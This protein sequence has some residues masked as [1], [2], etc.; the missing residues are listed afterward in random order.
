ML[1]SILVISLGASLGAVLRWALGLAL[2]GL[3]ETIPA[4]TLTDP[5]GL[6]VPFAPAE[7]VMVWGGMLT[8]LATMVWLLDTFENV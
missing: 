4:G 3:F 5:M 6:I 2:N 8:K 7:D 1:N